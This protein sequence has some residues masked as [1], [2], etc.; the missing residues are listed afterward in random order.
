MK[1]HD[2]GKDCLA[3][4]SAYRAVSS[5]ETLP[6]PEGNY[7][8]SKVQV[9]PSYAACLLSFFRFLIGNQMFKCTNLLELQLVIQNTNKHQNITD[10]A[11]QL[12]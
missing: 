2:L 6:G 4:G 10:T 5:R 1:G 11:S 8:L 12:F 7:E 9:S 3:S